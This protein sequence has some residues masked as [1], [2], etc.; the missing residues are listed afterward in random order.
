M[1]EEGRTEGLEH[2]TWARGG[3]SDWGLHE[4]KREKRQPGNEGC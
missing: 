1:E 4:A 2:A 3:R